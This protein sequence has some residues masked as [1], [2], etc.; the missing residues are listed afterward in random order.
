[1]EAGVA[2]RLPGGA[3]PEPGD[4]IVYDIADLSFVVMR[5]ETGEI[6]AYPNACLHRGRKLKDYDGHC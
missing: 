5:T 1:M 6:K 3:H 4:Y 2:V